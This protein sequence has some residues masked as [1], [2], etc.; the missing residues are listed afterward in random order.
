M[1]EQSRTK[2]AHFRN[3]NFKHKMKRLQIPQKLVY[4]KF[5]VHEI[6]AVISS[7]NYFLK[8][9]KKTCKPNNRDLNRDWIKQKQMAMK[10]YTP[11]KYNCSK[12]KKLLQY[13]RAY[14]ENLFTRLV[15]Q[16]K[17]LFEIGIS[18]NFWV[19]TFFPR[20]KN[21]EIYLEPNQTSRWNFFAKIAHNLQ[22]LM[23]SL[24]VVFAKDKKKMSLRNVW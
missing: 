23:L 12:K 17:L 3:I 21:S 9:A 6:A 22:S 8:N 16:I 18:K 2:V 10:R 11:L 13:Q 15:A 4:K 5:Y 7:K 1:K 14:S 24:L 19:I 20:I